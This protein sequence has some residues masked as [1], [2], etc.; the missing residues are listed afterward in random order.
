MTRPGERV[1]GC[2]IEAYRGTVILVCIHGPPGVGKLS[3]GR[4]LERMTGYILVHDH[5]VIETAAVVFPFGE[6]GFSNL[7]SQLFAD[8]LHAACSTRRGILLTHANDIFWNPTFETLLRNSV[9]R[10]GYAVRRVFLHCD[11]EE[12]ARR[13]SD[14]RRAQYRKIREIERLR[15]LTA[16]GEFSAPPILRGDLVIDTTEISATE[17]AAQIA[18]SLA[19]TDQVIR[20]V[21]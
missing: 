12:H 8:L 18:F 13:I 15:D 6:D 16:A 1:A 5:L 20:K 4:Q 2:G 14:P 7:R 10:F 17:T 21:S 3:V 11:E 9:G 19:L